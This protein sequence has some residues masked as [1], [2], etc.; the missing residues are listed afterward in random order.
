MSGLILSG[1][2]ALIAYGF[3]LG[4]APK[5]LDM[6]GRTTQSVAI[7]GRAGVTPL[8]AP[9]EQ[10]RTLT[11]KGTIMGAD[12]ADARV[13]LDALK[14]AL[15]TAPLTITFSD[16][17]DR[18]VYADPEG[19]SSP[20]AE[21]GS[22]I[23]KDLPVEITLQCMDPLSYDSAFTSLVIPSGQTIVLPMGTGPVLPLLSVSG[24]S[25]NPTIILT[26]S[27]GN[28]WG[29]MYFNGLALSA[30]DSLVVDC[31]AMTVRVDNA[32]A[33]SRWTAGDF[34]E[35]DPKDIKGA[36]IQFGGGGTLSVAYRRSW[37]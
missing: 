33:L 26:D 36:R 31:E 9:Q 20:P 5:W 29:E 8:A 28:V 16:H 30:S 32:N 2:D 3:E 18:M 12:A 6:P 24:A 13:K 17:P 27:N 15:V 25:T 4:S 10:P 22:H 14:L 7:P 19:L 37:R 21:M 1:V 35:I 11:L 23:A 34:I